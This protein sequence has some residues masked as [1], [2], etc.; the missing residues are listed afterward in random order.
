MKIRALGISNGGRLIGCHN[1]ILFKTELSINNCTLFQGKTGR[2]N[3]CMNNWNFEKQDTFQI[4]L[5]TYKAS[6]MT[7]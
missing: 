2:N 6:E 1:L 7:Q 3:F 4:D 5:N